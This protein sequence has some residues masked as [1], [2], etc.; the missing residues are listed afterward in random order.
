MRTKAIWKSEWDS[1]ANATKIALENESGQIL[2]CRKIFAAEIKGRFYCLL[3]PEQTVDGLDEHT[4]LPF[5]ANHH[6]SLSI[7][8]DRTI[9]ERLFAEYYASLESG[10]KMK[11][12][13]NDG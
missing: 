10:V 8:K 7:V 2:Q 13:S 5:R 9:C 1:I 11:R 6:G 12:R 3:V 4:A